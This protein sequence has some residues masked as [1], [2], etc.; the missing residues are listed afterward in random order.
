M[1]RFFGQS[2]STRVPQP[3]LND[4][5]ATLD[6]RVET[7]NKQIASVDQGLI[8]RNCFNPINISLF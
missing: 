4:T 8:Y 2:K 3:T 1:N 5:A 6:S 7:I